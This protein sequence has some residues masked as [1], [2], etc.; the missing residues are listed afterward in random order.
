M[1]RA[2]T[3]SSSASDSAISSRRSSTFVFVM[4]STADAEFGIEN[5]VDVELVELGGGL[6]T[7][8]EALVDPL[9]QAMHIP[10]P[11][12]EPVRVETSALGALGG[13]RGGRYCRVGARRLASS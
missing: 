1:S 12:V 5:V 9:E 3:E 4:A 8:G 2:S 7:A 11:V 6:S 10:S 13:L